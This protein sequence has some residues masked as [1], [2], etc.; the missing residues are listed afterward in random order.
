MRRPPRPPSPPPPPP[1]ASAGA[2]APD[3]RAPRQARGQQR[4]EAILDA[5]AAAFLEVGVAEASVHDIARRARSS[6]GS[7]YH[8]F[9]GKD[10]LVAALLRRYEARFREIVDTL[11]ARP[12]AEWAALPLDRFVDEFFA[13]F[14]AFLEHNP[15]YVVL[16][17]TPHGPTEDA[18]IEAAMRRYFLEILALRLP[19]LAPAA[20][21]RCGALIFAMGNGVFVELSMRPR[22]GSRP[23]FTELQ[24]AVAAYLAT[25][26]SGGA[27]TPPR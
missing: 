6:V 5:A 14:V 11:H 2:P 22:D 27:L 12:P 16:A 24:R 23:L 21:A 18:E 20:R 26:E 4:V 9:S 15:A 7:L 19:H 3:G 8:F 13:P 17:A 10:A 25:Y 1:A